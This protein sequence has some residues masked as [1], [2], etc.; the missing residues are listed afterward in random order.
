M[1]L[2]DMLKTGS[3]LSLT[4]LIGKFHINIELLPN[5]EFNGQ[6]F[7][8]NFVTKPMAKYVPPAVS[9]RLCKS[10]CLMEIN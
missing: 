4:I 10:L 3:N 5:K 1:S 7:G 9:M 6:T 2:D 8:Q